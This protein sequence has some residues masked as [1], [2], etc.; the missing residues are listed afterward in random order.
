[1]LGVPAV[2]PLQQL[3]PSHVPSSVVRPQ[4]QPQVQLQDATRPQNLLCAMKPCYSHA[5][6]MKLVFFLSPATD[7][8]SFA[9]G[10][11]ATE[12]GLQVSPHSSAG[13]CPHYQGR[14]GRDHSWVS[15]TC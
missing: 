11:R 3:G 14:R 8:A 10:L 2:F 6:K 5:E 4:L 7:L 9:K 1:M 12:Q 13:S 15:L